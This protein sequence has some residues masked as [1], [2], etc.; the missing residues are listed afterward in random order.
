MITECYVN[1]PI[2]DGIKGICVSGG[3]DSALLL[4]ILMKNCPEHLYIFTLAKDL[5]GRAA[6]IIA[7]NVIEKCIQLTNNN[8]VTHIVSFAQ[9]QTMTE[10]F[11]MPKEY[12]NN[13][14]ISRYYTGVTCNPPKE[15]AD[16]FCGPELNTEC[17]IRDPLVNRNVFGV[18]AINP[19]TNIDKQHIAS[20]YEALGLMESLFP[21]TRSCEV[22]GRLNY[23]SHCGTC[24]WCKERMWGFNKLD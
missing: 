10:L 3:A 14:I 24:W 23:Y 4:Y 15:I 18:D 17:I 2:V 16:S 1:I 11:M 6:A 8:N 13:N 9:V 22:S 21:I 12:Q 7:A 19:F 5:N 20:M